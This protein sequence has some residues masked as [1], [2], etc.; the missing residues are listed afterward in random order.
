[1]RLDFIPEL[2]VFTGC[3]V[4]VLLGLLVCW[5]LLLAIVRLVLAAHTTTAVSLLL[6]RLGAAVREGRSWEP[7]LRGL[8]LEMPWPWPWRLGRAVESLQAGTPPAEVLAGSGL[9]PASL[10]AQAAQALH[11]GPAAFA[12]WCDAVADRAP[13]NPLAVRQQA[14][15][16]AECAAVLAV[17]WFMSTFIFPKFEQI[18]WELG[19]PPPPLLR[20]CGSL[21]DYTLPC[22]VGIVTVAATLWSVGLAAAWR[23]RRRQAAGRLLLAGSIARLPEAALG[24]AGGFAELCAAAGWRAGDP[25]GLARQLARAETRDA[26]RRAWLPSVLAAVTPLVAAIPVG[27]MI[28]GMMQVILRILTSIE[29]Q[30]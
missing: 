19:V 27:L 14:F 24:G 18:L 17:L 15:L 8:R 6:A 25:A 26:L 29:V 4:G 7:V 5:Q 23:R 16:L 20:I 12:Q 9:L 1:M 30:S 22:I 3:T 11:Q 28:I 21:Q 13:P 2:L 10:R